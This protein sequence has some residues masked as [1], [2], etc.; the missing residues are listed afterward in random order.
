MH[1]I[2]YVIMAAL[3]LMVLSMFVI[4]IRDTLEARRDKKMM[5]RVDT[6][7]NASHQRLNEINRALQE[8]EKER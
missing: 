4:A 7:L 2:V 1:W 5:E 3:A 6:L 8:K